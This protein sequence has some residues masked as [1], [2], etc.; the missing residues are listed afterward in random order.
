[1]KKYTLVTNNPRVIDKV[2]RGKLAK[3]IKIKINECDNLDEVMKTSRDLIHLG[4]RLITHPLAGS[5]KPAQNPY[6]SIILIEE[7]DLDYYS[8]NTMEKAIVKLRQFKKTKKDIEYPDSILEDYQ[9]IDYSLISSG[10]KSL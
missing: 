4:Y 6:R 9:V 8:L 5:V 3:E 10:I 2:Q 1:M 7:N